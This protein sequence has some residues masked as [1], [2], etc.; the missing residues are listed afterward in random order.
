MPIYL[1][2][3]AALSGGGVPIP[4]DELRH[5]ADVTPPSKRA[6]RAENPEPV[7]PEDKARTKRPEPA[8][9]P[10]PIP[11]PT[12]ETTTSTALTGGWAV[13]VG[14]YAERAS[15]MRVAGLIDREGVVILPTRSNGRDYYVVLL[16]TW[17]SREEADDIGRTYV[18][19]TDYWVRSTSG[20]Q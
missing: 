20:L 19:E 12:P 4:P 6:A 2:L 3:I 18:A 10:E 1:I 16:G 11:E 17:P 8:P 7:P 13:Q 5:I 14:A 9:Q 15:A